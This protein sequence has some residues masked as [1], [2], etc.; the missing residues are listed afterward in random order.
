M[1]QERDKEIEER[2]KRP[3]FI[4]EQ[5]ILGVENQGLALDN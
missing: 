4:G 5:D 3:A 1:N 2:N